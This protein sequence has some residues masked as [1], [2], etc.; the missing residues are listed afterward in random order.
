[1]RYALVSSDMA[2]AIGDVV[3][4]KYKI[5]RLLG[6]GGMG[7]VFEG[8][9]TRIHRRVAIKVL[10]AGHDSNEEAVRRFER[11]AQAAGR[12]GSEHI[13]EVLDL[14]D[15]PG[16]ERYMVMEFLDGESLNERIGRGAM[17]A[18][19]IANIAT[20][21]LEGLKAAHSAQIVHR[22]LKPD[23]VFLLRNRSG[24]R[25][26]VKIVDFGIS[27][28]NALGGEFSMTRTGTVMGTP[29]YMSPEQA[30]GGSTVDQRADL[31]A[32]GVILY[33]AVV[34]KVPFQAETFNELLFKIVLE[35]PPKLSDQV[36]DLDPRFVDIVE[37]AMARDVDE[38]FQT[39]EALQSALRAWLG[40]VAIPAGET[41]GAGTPIMDRTLLPAQVGPS[42]ATPGLLPAADLRTTAR[43]GTVPEDDVVPKDDVAPTV[44]TAAVELGKANEDFTIEG[45][46]LPSPHGRGKVVL[47]GAA[48]VLSLLLGGIAFSG[49]GANAE[50]SAHQ[51]LEMKALEERAVIQREAD[52]G[53]AELLLELEK[54]RALAQEAR[55]KAVQAQR[56]AEKNKLEAEAQRR[57]SE[58]AQEAAETAAQQRANLARDK[59][60]PRP[61]PASVAPPKPTPAPQSAP[62]SPKPQS[63]RII[64]TD[65]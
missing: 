16:G 14:G 38:R 47:I 61:R 37:K 2:L 5:V 57:A 8:E 41:M 1:M 40:G 62:A 49:M 29:Y 53:R 30:K 39:A 19:D 23:N 59:L 10:H 26:F 48:L 22:D 35:T 32:V 24:E 43:S 63:G 18:R 55:E 54:E 60:R 58:A 3:D 13:V 64:R 46:G 27:K 20:G 51:A 11:E 50:E 36:K 34:G 15:L 7:A 25:D 6:E 21:L 52:A 33:Q 4:G 17:K 65:I 9:N 28:F 42:M 45:A 31:Y 56:E 44:R 12:I